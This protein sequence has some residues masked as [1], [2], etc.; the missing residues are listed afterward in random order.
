M[1]ARNGER[2]Q[3]LLL[4]CLHKTF[5]LELIGG[6]LV[7]YH[8]LFRKVPVSSSSSFLTGNPYIAVIFTVPGTL[9]HHNITSSRRRFP[10]APRDSRHLSLYLKTSLG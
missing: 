2:L 10:N 8:R 7:S 4:E 1:P 5:A 3:F 6:V 9:S